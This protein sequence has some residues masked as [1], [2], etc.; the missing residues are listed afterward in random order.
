MAM[1]QGPEGA[2]LALPSLG[3]A[4]LLNPTEAL[5]LVACE[6]PPCFVAVGLSQARASERE[7][8]RELAVIAREL[9]CVLV[10]FSSH[11][12]S[13]PPS[14]DVLLCEEVDPPRPWVGDA[15]GPFRAPWRA[16]ADGR[17]EPSKLER[18]FGSLQSSPRASLALIQLLRLS[19]SLSVQDGLIAES[20]VYSMLQSGR[21]FKSWLDHSPWRNWPKKTQEGPPVHLER[22]RLFTHAAQSGTQRAIPEE[23]LTITLTRVRARNAVDTSMRDALVEAF[24]LAEELGRS[25]EIRRVELCAKGKDFCSGGDLSEFGTGPD[26]VENHLIRTLRSPAIGLARATSVLHCAAQLHGAC[27]GAGIELAC[28]CQETVAKEGTWFLLPEVSMGLIPGS[29]GTVSIPRRIGR[30]RT[31]WMALT[32]E[33]IDLH[34]ALSWGLV[35][36]VRPEV[37]GPGTKAGSLGNGEKEGPAFFS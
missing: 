36:A 20:F 34:T 19:A 5:E 26:P 17:E 31:A 13:D 37:A 9:P 33:A 7:A 14:F 32:G 30:E 16:G 23:V 28:F 29:G 24:E 27:V 4:R 15:L 6:P 11:P 1:N 35:D 3:P 22:R 2:S 8:C 18:L 21:E 25:G 12:L 10:G